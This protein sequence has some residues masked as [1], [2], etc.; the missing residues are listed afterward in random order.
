MVVDDDPGITKI[1]ETTLKQL[2]VEADIFTASDGIE[3]LAAI[4]KH[5]ADVVILDVMMPRM[6]G[7]AVCDA[8][9]K[10]I[11][12]AVSSDP[13]AY[14]EWRPSQP[15][16]KDTWSGTDDYMSK[17]FEVADFLA[18]ASADCCGEHTDCNLQDYYAILGAGSRRLTRVDQDCVPPTGP[19]APSGSARDFDRGRESVRRGPHGP[20]ERGLRRPFARQEPERVRRETAPGD[21]LNGQGDDQHRRHTNCD[22]SNQD[23]QRPA[24]PQGDA[25]RRGSRLDGR[26]AICGSVSRNLLERSSRFLVE[27]GPV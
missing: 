12:T 17:P 15:H 23:H 8:L 13:D 18:T 3:A 19:L 26:K 20:A 7:F 21:D 4:E 25:A 11:R 14:R 24:I 1:I 22:H 5:G 10:D 9:R 2:P 27:E 16:Q 6:D